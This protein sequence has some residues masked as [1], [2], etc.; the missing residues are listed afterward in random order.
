MQQIQ[1]LSP[2][3]VCELTSLSRSTLDRL[4]ADGQFPRPTRITPRRLAF[5]SVAVNGW[6]N[7]REAA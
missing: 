7:E 3:R 5:N 2:K 4:V 1:L 6:I